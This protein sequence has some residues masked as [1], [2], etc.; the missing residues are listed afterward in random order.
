MIENNF[1]AENNIIHQEKEQQTR[2]KSVLKLNVGSVNLELKDIP[3]W[4]LH[5]ANIFSQIGNPDNICAALF[6][7]EEIFHTIFQARSALFFSMNGDH[8][9]L[10]GKNPELG[11]KNMLKA[12]FLQYSLFLYNICLDLSLQVLWVRLAKPCGTEWEQYNLKKCDKNALFNSIKEDSEKIFIDMI[13]HIENFYNHTDV[14]PIR[15]LYNRLKHCETFY[16]QG[17][18][19]ND[20]TIPIGIN[21]KKVEKFYREEMIFDDWEK[22]LALFHNEFIDYF[23]KIVEVVAPKQS[24]QIKLDK[25]FF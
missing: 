13:K 22:K 6:K 10:L 1:F 18:G 16:V 14:R 12:M 4:H 5:N 11:S 23:D 20:K 25:K 9:A 2:Q 7:T 17:V 21:N 15:D 3:Y 19:D 24:N 8:D